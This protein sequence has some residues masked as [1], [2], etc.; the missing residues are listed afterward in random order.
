MTPIIEKRDSK[1]IE[2]KPSIKWIELLSKINVKYYLYGYKSNSPIT[3]YL[4]IID[5]LKGDY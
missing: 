1:M 5:I 2:I 3:E 4:Y